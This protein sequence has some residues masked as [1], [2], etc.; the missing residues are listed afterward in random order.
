MKYNPR[1]KKGSINS[2][3]TVNNSGII[4]PTLG[5]NVKVNDVDNDM[6]QIH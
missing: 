6:S 3:N 1:L 5:F 2:K 4:T